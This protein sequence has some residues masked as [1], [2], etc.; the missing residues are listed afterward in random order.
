MLKKDKIRTIIV[1]KWNKKT[2]K[3]IKR[4]MIVDKPTN[5]KE[6]MSIIQALLKKFRFK[7][8]FINVLL[9]KQSYPEPDLVEKLSDEQVSKIRELRLVRYDR[10]VA[11]HYDEFKNC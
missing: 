7:T 3:P 5:S 9:D 4:I 11:G 8:M 2:N 1:E 10:S 6:L